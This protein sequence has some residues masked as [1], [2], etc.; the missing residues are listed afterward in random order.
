MLKAQDRSFLIAVYSF[1]V[2]SA[3]FEVNQTW[4]QIGY[5]KFADVVERKD[6]LNYVHEKR[7]ESA[8]YYEKSKA[9]TRVGM[10]IKRLQTRMNTGFLTCHFAL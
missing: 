2:V 8:V 1:T 4:L 6:Y 5:K 3:G 10:T 9:S 7:I